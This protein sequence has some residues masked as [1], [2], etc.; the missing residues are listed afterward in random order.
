M[1]HHDEVVCVS[2]GVGQHNN[3]NFI[4]LRADVLRGFSKGC[5][6]T[7]AIMR[8][9]NTVILSVLCECLSRVRHNNVIAGESLIT[10]FEWSDGSIFDTFLP[11]ATHVF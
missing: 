7:N 10:V 8:S 5:M 6:Q 2:T 4:S 1:S 11:E 9:L 3:T